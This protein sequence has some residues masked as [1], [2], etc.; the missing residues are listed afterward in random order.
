MKRFNQGEWIGFILLTG[1][2]LYVAYLLRNGEIISFIHPKRV[3]LMWTALGGL[4]ILVIYQSSKIF[5]IPAR[6][7]SFKSYYALSF[8]LL[9]G[10]VTLSAKETDRFTTAQTSNNISITARRQ[11]SYRAESDVLEDEFLSNEYGSEPDPLV[12]EWLFSEPDY[13]IY[14]EGI[15]DLEIELSDT[16]LLTNENYIKTL[17]DIEHNPDKYKDKTIITEGFV[18]RDP[19][20]A[21]DEFVIARM[22][23]ICCAAD[24]QITGL[25]CQGEKSISLP[26]RQ[27]VR[28]EGVLKIESYELDGQQSILPIIQIQE[29][30]EL[31]TPDNQYIYY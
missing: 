8:V 4:I 13:D 10:V 23:M 24:A 27:W 19:Q 11:Q 30:Q 1:L 6:K 29:V 14:E 3:P 7:T 28:I 12:D 17:T 2:A 16:I 20:F 25:M 5:T 22:Y 31:P 18:Y 26:Y 9:C 21:E 15:E